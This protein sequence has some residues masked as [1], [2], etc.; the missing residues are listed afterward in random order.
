[1]AKKEK[2]NIKKYDIKLKTYKNDLKHNCED[3]EIYAG[4]F[5][6]V[7]FPYL[8]KPLLF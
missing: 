7:F 6:F 1:L 8:I 4:Y 2:N 5:L 3:K